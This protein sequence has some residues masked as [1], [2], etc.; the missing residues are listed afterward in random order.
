M[1]KIFNR[2]IGPN[3]SQEAM[4]YWIRGAR[5][6]KQ[7]L[8]GARAN[9]GISQAELAALLGV[10]RV[11]MVSLEAGKNSGA[12]RLIEAFNLLGFDLIAVP[13]TATVQVDETGA[14]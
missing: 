6:V 14:D 9:K 12:M 7:A 5:G 3:G 10:D 2:T 4:W 11:T 1:L 8:A 13:R